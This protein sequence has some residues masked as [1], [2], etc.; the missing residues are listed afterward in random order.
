MPNVLIRDVPEDVHV[1][2]QARAH[3]HGQS[4]QQYLAAELC[5]LAER[6]SMDEVLGRI[7]TRRGGHVGLEQAEQ[8]LTVEPDRG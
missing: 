3:K 1:R 4:L 5:R 6:P 7:A 2:L 8:D